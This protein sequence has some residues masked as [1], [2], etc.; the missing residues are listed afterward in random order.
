MGVYR[1]LLRSGLDGSERSA[2]A[3]WW[4]LLLRLLLVVLVVVVMVTLIGDWSLR[5]D[6]DG[7]G[8]TRCDAL[9]SRLGGRRRRLAG[10]VRSSALRRLT[11]VRT[12][13]C[14]VYR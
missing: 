3:G 13:T 1:Q 5:R 7:L 8:T 2:G 6:R 10:L 14:A 9:H 11:C 4:T 12:T